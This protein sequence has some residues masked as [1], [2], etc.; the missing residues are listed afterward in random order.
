[1]NSGRRANLL[2]APPSSS[3]TEHDDERRQ[4]VL[5]AVVSAFVA[6]AARMWISWGRDEYAIWPDEPAQLAIARFL[7]GGTRWNMH[8]HSVWR[9]LFGTLLAPAHWFTDDPATILHVAFWLNAVLG[10]AAA[11]LL[12]ILVRRLTPLTPLVAGAVAMVVSLSP[13]VL[14]TSDFVFAESLVLPLYL[15]T[16]L[17]GLR[18]QE[19]PT[20][21]GGLAA[22]LLA[23]A[24]FGAHSRML[25]L[26]FVVIGIVVVAAVRR[27]MGRMDAVASVAVAV[28]AVVVT[29]AYT[30]VLVER[31]WDEP[32]T[33]NSADGVLDQATNIRAIAIA[34]IGQTWSLLVASVGVVVYGTVVLARAARSRARP[35]D[36]TRADATIVLVVVGACTA[37][38]VV[39]MA[40]RW[41][42][43]QLVYGRYNAM[44]VVPLLVVGAAV[45]VGEVRVRRFGWVVG[46][47]A[48]AT[49]ATGVL[50]WLLR[51]DLLRSSNGIEPM[52]LGLQPF[53]TSMV[54]ID[55]P[56]ITLW[57]VGWILAL[58]AMVVVMRQ[59]RGRQ[60]V[61]IVMLGGLV[62]VG[63]LRTRSVIDRLWDDSGGASAVG[64]LRDGAL[65]D[66]VPVD[67][68]LREGSNSTVAM[69]LYQ[70]HLPHTEFT[71]VSDPLAAGTSD[72]V[73]A[74][75][76]NDALLD[77]G[78]QVLWTDP[79]RP[80]ALWER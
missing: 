12:V 17:V 18:L 57:A 31:I 5:A 73:F 43:D 62:L 19:A 70:F 64:R 41:R 55:V 11:V 58:G 50:L 37:L 63:S 42:S 23:A 80:I 28:A 33:L 77:S 38:S 27:R 7:G 68:Y 54:S 32:S 25:P 49:V 3:V 34:L 76:D 78:A 51:R 4:W 67:Y 69:M 59:R 8:D 35:G 1:V 72:Y 61:A 52:I 65:V 30:S 66:G 45:V 26:T 10:A 39:F 9:P 36:P 53:I 22:G 21:A 14:F 29:S 16:I 46:A 20:L 15:A 2:E 24:A 74:P 79:R 47:T 60:A 13:A 71:V 56:R 44:A 48:A 6:L 75:T 40:D